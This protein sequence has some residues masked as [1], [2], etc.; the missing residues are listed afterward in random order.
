MLECDTILQQLLDILVSN[1]SPEDG[2]P[3]E[4]DNITLQENKPRRGAE[5]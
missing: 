1:L 4:D 3:T 2:I 5:L